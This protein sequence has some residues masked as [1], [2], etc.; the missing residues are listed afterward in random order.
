MKIQNTICPLFCVLIFGCYQQDAFEKNRTVYLNAIGSLQSEKNQSN[1]SGVIRLPPKFSAASIDGEAVVSTAY[2]NNFI[3]VFK[4][5]RGKGSNM[6]GYLYTSRPLG[7]SEIHT[8]Y[9]GDP[10]L[11]VNSVDLVLGKQVQSNWYAVSF[12]LD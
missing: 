2:T 12:R 4:T 7:K 5:W 1:W 10:V 9:Y 6:E 11:D 3:A 8:N